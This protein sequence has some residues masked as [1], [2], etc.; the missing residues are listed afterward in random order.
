MT[1][2]KQYPRHTG[3]WVGDDGSVFGPN[4]K[5]LKPYIVAKNKK[6]PNRQ[7]YLAVWVNGKSVYVH[8]MVLETFD[9]PKPENMECRHLDGDTFNN[10][11]C[12]LEW[13]TKL[14]NAEDAK[15]HGSYEKMVA[16]REL[17]RIM[18]HQ[19]AALP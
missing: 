4:G 2:Y 5:L 3:Y 13:G 7:G 1:E 10:A 6:K 15:R 16:A 18:S 9:K 17:G 12:N 19:T 14:E 8:V 11:F